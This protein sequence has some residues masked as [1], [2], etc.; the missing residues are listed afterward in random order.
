[1]HKNLRKTQKKRAT[2]NMCVLEF[3]ITFEVI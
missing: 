1:M 2:T 3:Q